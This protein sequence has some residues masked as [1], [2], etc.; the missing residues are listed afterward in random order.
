[1]T[2]FISQQNIDKQRLSIFLRDLAGDV[3]VNLKH[4]I[5]DNIINEEKM[6]EEI[7]GISISPK[8]EFN[9]IKIWL[10]NDTQTFKSL[11]K[12]INPYFSKNSKYKK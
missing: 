1:M 10:R 11:V 9:I 2:T 6:W 3:K 12:E 5:E 8:K 4:M 7:N